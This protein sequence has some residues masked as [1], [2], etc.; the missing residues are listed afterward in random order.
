MVYDNLKVSG[1]TPS[2]NVSCR[3]L[4]HWR[5]GR[6]DVGFNNVTFDVHL[7]P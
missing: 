7:S 2:V 6:P 5:G 1:Y 4:A 3:C